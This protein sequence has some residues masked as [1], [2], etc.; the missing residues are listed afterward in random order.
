MT[1]LPEPTVRREVELGSLRALELSD[2]DWTRPLGIIHRRNKS[3]TTV[4]EKFV[5]LLHE[6]P[7]T[8]SAGEK[9]RKQDSKNGRSPELQETEK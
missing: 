1:L 7:A 5:E 8:F 4:G 2:A 6:D 9:G 3:L